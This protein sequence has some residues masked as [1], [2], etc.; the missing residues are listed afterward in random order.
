MGAQGTIA[1]Q[2]NQEKRGFLTIDTWFLFGNWTL[3]GLFFS[4]SALKPVYFSYFN[5]QFFFQ[6]DTFYI[7]IIVQCAAV[8]N[9]I[10][11]PRVSVW[12]VV[13]LGGHFTCLCQ[14]FDFYDVKNIIIYQK[15]KGNTFTIL[16]IFV[17]RSLQ[18]EHNNT[19]LLL[20]P[21]P[22]CRN[23]CAITLKFTFGNWY[24]IPIL[25]LLFSSQNYI[26]PKTV[27]PWGTLLIKK[28][29]SHLL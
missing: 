26:G 18:E 23:K 1:R 21:P 22:I 25:F 28:K 3:T 10:N 7:M 5:F 12:G 4:I 13:S 17:V 15:E 11:N 16:I 27:R 14:G 6:D 19:N 2:Y 29:L 9:S 8:I 20:W 24:C